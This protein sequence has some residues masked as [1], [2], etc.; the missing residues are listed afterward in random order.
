MYEFLIYES[1]YIGCFRNGESAA[2][3]EEQCPGVLS[4][5][6][7]PRDEELAASGRH[8]ERGRHETE[9]DHQEAGHRVGHVVFLEEGGPP[10]NE[11]RFASDPQQ[12]HQEY[13]NHRNP[14]YRAAIE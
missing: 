2:H 14:F 12:Y 4:F 1:S 8:E 6:L 13:V 11:A 9:S 3:N 7:L 10:G 5:E